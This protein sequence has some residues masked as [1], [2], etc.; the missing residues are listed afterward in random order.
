MNTVLQFAFVPF[1]VCLGVSPHQL[2]QV[3]F[4]SQDLGGVIVWLCAITAPPFL[5]FRAALRHVEV[6]RLG[7]ESEPQPQ[8][9]QIRAASVTCAAPCSNADP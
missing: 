8:P 7:V 5:L 1:M 3:A 9:C 6:P 4:F 2:A